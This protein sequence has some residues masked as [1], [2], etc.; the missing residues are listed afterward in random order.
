MK[1]IVFL[2]LALTLLAGCNKETESTF[3]LAP[4]GGVISLRTQSELKDNSMTGVTQ[5]LSVASGITRGFPTLTST[6]NVS[7]NLKLDPSMQ[8]DA[9]TSSTTCDVRFIIEISGQDENGDRGEL[10]EK[11]V[12]SYKPASNGQY[13]INLDLADGK[14]YI[15]VWM[16]YVNENSV[17]DKYYE[18]NSLSSISVNTPYVG[19]EDF[20]EVYVA[21]QVIEVS[22]AA[23][24]DMTLKQPMGKFEF[25]TTDIEKF[26]GEQADD[27]DLSTLK[28]HV[29]YS[30]FLPTEFNAYTNKPSDSSTG[31][32]FNCSITQLANGKARLA[33]DYVFVTG[34]E[35]SVQVVLSIYNN[36]GELLNSK[37]FEAVPIQQG[38]LT[39][40]SGAFLSHNSD[41]GIA[42]NPSLDGE[43]NIQIP[44]DELLVYTF[45]AWTCDANPRRVMHKTTTGTLSAAAIEITLVPG[46]Y[47]FL[48]W[49]DYGKGEYTT[50]DLRQVLDNRHNSNIG[51]GNS[52]M[53]V[54]ES[55]C[56]AFAAVERVAWKGGESA[57]TLRRPMAK[58]NIK[59][60]DP[61]TTADKAVS[62]TYRNV[63]T[64]YDVL[65]GLTSEPVQEITYS[66][67]ATAAGSAMVGED[68]L[69]VPTQDATPVGLVITVGGVTRELGVL[70]LQSNYR[71]V[72]T[73]RFE[74]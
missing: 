67:P 54:F 8:F 38:Q 26:L 28:V 30:G 23:T 14:Y 70:P 35:S 12:Q 10:L 50:E 47:Y 40:I 39:T 73:A 37:H 29:A 69:F 61:F 66:F 1:K 17:E 63:P 53:P 7:L 32:S 33:S 57:V 24:L 71:T 65:T 15:T 52:S 4:V 18:T 16:D 45:E 42:I 46:D 31:I 68:F 9:Q 44:D 58:L 5:K 49:A 74:D 3:D 55:V 41:F 60:T 27:F 59:N 21:Q 64:R 56:D 13:P 48:F 11:K 72:V 43:F 25:I 36:E 6:S 51:Q 62:V 20:K 2:L 19:N 34:S 22:G